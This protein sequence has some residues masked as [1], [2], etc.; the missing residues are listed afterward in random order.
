MVFAEE[1]S[2][3]AVPASI[4]FG[5]HVGRLFDRLVSRPSW[6]SL[7]SIQCCNSRTKPSVSGILVD[8]LMPELRDF[9][10]R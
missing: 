2:C 3:G 1:K 10:S 8:A 7:P 9:N 6:H 5:L 4:S